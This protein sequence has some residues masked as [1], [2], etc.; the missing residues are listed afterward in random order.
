MKLTTDKLPAAQT[1]SNMVT[2][3]MGISDN[4]EDQLMILNVLSST[5]YTDKVAAVLREYGCNAFDANVEAGKGTVPIV[6]SLPNKMEP[7]LCIRDFGFGMTEDQI[8][9]TFVKLGRS[10]KRQSNEFTGML[11]IGSKSGFAYGDSFM[12]TSYTG[13]TKT[14][15]N[16]FRD[17]GAPRLARMLVVKDFGEPDGIEIKVPV[18]IEHFEE[19]RQKAERVYRYF[20]VRPKITGA[21]VDF[22]DSERIMSGQGWHYTGSGKSIAIMGNVGYDLTSSGMG[23][24]ASSLPNAAR[25][26][27]DLG[28]ELEF[29]IGDLEIA[30]SREG[31]QYKDVTKKAVLIRLN[32][33]VAA[34]GQKFTADI[35]AAPSLWAA[36]QLY[37]EIF[38]KLGSQN[39]R[40]LKDVIDGHV[41]W[42]GK[43][44][45]TGRFDIANKEADPEVNVFRVYERWKGARRSREPGAP[46]T[47]ASKNTALVINDLSGGKQ[48]PARERGFF[49][50]PANANVTEWILFTFVT[51]A[52]QKRYWKARN[53][54]GAPTILLSSI[55]PA[56]TAATTG[57][58][59][60]VH[61]SKHSAK[62][63]V[64]DESG[65][66]KG[67]NAARS[68][69]WT[70]ETVDM[71]TD[72]GVYVIL[73]SFYVKKPPTVAFDF[74]EHPEQFFAKV[75]L[76]RAA[77]L[78]KGPVYGFKIAVA[79]KLGP[80]WILLVDAVNAKLDEFITKQ[81]AAQ[82]AA[83]YVAAY[84]HLSLIDPKHEKEFPASSVLDYLKQINKMRTPKDA[85]LMN[86]IL[87]RDQVEPWAK[88]IT[89]PAASVNLDKI[90]ANVRK[91]YPLLD[92]IDD[93]ENRGS[94]LIKHVAEY[95]RLVVEA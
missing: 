15:Y 54:D 50:D 89:V 28:V 58:G 5:L 93:L 38:E 27:L 17:R 4:A 59:P 84:Q 64:L 36:H 70:Q 79:G 3:N 23:G 49:E 74:L 1:S 42:K 29:E 22:L 88:E 47:Y 34:I 25:V 62:A 9:N 57:G 31:L 92:L 95:V 53:L 51:P 55:T 8:A 66:P 73:D 39:T 20:K 69:Y 40:S 45:N 10:T 78:I 30:A 87:H 46:W 13:G 67:Y 26:L 65:T 33:M 52:A 37:G 75:K 19:F 35:T 83:D 85:K 80:G 2:L 77:G 82:D 14:V 18:R 76:L 90:K 7:S 86:V 68:L 32:H 61:N 16:A 43:V 11:G 48:S 71:A 44:I 60:R 6:V 91:E 41:K 63:F 21:R 56:V 12:V 72:S 81:G 94:V 24:Y